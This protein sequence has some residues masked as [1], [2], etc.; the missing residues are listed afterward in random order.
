MKNYL[1]NKD[2]ERTYLDHVTNILIDPYKYTPLPMH[3]NVNKW[4]WEGKDF[5]RV[6]AV[7]EFEEFLRTNKLNFNKLLCFNGDSDPE[8]EFLNKQ[9]RTII[10]YEADPINNDLHNLNLKEKDYDFC[11][12]NQ[13]L[14]HLYDPIQCLKNVYAHLRTGGVFYC[15]VPVVNIPHMTPFHH[16]SGFTPTGLGCIAEAAGF[17]ILSLG[18]WGNKEYTVKMFQELSW[19]TYQDLINPGFNE[20]DYP[21]IAWIFCVKE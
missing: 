6:I 17:K 20:F 16:Y 13:T 7:L 11:M 8:F 10:N 12:L 9:G 3:K 1:N 19:P 5:A 21:V 15:N 2:V 4:R 14:E 18:S